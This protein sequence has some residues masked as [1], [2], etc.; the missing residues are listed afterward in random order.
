M[1][2]SCFA[3]RAA[4]RLQQKQVQGCIDDCT[5]AIHLLISDTTFDLQSDITDENSLPYVKRYRDNPAEGLGLL[6]CLTRQRTMGQDARKMKNAILS[7]VL[8]RR[9]S[10]FCFLGDLQKAADDFA[11]VIITCSLVLVHK[12]IST[13]SSDI[14]HTH[15][16]G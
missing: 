12:S 10:A 8:I 3:N 6:T 14:T 16:L 13:G 11:E 1:A 2:I 5:T 9:G 15:Y 7:R 4:C